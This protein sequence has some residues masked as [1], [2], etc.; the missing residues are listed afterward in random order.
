MSDQMRKAAAFQA[1]HTREEPLLLP[2]PWDA[3]SAKLMTSLGF[4]AL[5]T[6]SLGASAMLGTTIATAET[7][8]E[9]C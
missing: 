4:K 8:L 3:G 1:L 2:N 5:A 7:I 6:T 9:N